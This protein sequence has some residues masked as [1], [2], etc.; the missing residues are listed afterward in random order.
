MIT[1]VQAFSCHLPSISWLNLSG[2]I[3]RWSCRC[4][5]FF[6][7]LQMN[8]AKDLV[9]LTSSISMS[10]NT[11]RGFPWKIEKVR[12][13]K[14]KHKK[15]AHHFLNQELHQCKHWPDEK[16]IADPRQRRTSSAWPARGFALA[17]VRGCV[18]PQSTRISTSSFLIKLYT[19]HQHFLYL[20]AHT[21]MHLFRPFW[22]L[23]K[24]SWSRWLPKTGANQDTIALV[25][26]CT[27]AV[28]R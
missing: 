15:L 13:K 23:G 2:L 24:G 10:R 7:P 22:L 28:F 26:G 9:M 27:F 12:L 11:T 4:E 16:A 21:V 19:D 25:W 8:V 20:H 6:P 17:D 18:P 3:Q 5:G 14:K 1:S